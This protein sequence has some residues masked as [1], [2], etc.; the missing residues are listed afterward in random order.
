MAQIYSS[1]EYHKFKNYK[2]KFD[3]N[4]VPIEFEDM[5]IIDIN[6]EFVRIKDL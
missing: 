3:K 2:N 5:E 4:S 1:Q 6:Q